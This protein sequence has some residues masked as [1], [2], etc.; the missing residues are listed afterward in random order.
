[1]ARAV[2]AAPDDRDVLYWCSE[3]TATRA[4]AVVRL[5]GYLRRLAEGDDADRIAAARSGIEVLR[6]LGERSVWVSV[7]RPEKAEIPLTRIWDPATGTVQGFVIR[8]G[9]GEKRKPVP[10]LLDTG[11]PG[12]FVIR[13]AARKRG[14][15]SLAEQT[16]FGGGGDRRHVTSRGLFP[17]ATIGDLRFA[18]ALAS[19]N[20]QEMDPTGRYHGVIGLAVFNGYRVTLD[21]ENDRLLLDSPVDPADGETYWTIEGQWLVPGSVTGQPSL[22]LLD[23]G[24]THSAVDLSTAER[25]PGAR[26]GPPVTMHGFGGRIEGA[27]RV[28]GV[29]IAIQGLESGSG[30][31]NAVDLSTRSRLGGV[32]LSGFVG[33]DLLDGKRIVI[34]TVA[35]RIAI[36]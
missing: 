17:S 3:F 33:L 12:L 25:I 11:S 35:R 23:T 10:L 7:T 2:E 27:R 13:R 1:M 24:A 26:M 21:L 19:S 8:V 15:D 5:E 6:T 34:D 32:E 20:K 31:M 16:Q 14:F 36:R 29:E 4:E 22:L 9:L 28:S 18:D 30:P